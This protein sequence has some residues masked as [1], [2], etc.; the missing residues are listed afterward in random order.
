MAVHI[1]IMCPQSN[2]QKLAHSPTIAYVLSLIVLFA[3]FYYRT[4]L[5]KPGKVQPVEAKKVQ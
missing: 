4:Y 3:N 5:V 2:T 1:T